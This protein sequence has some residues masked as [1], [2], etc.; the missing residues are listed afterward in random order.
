MPNR[1]R[2]VPA[3]IVDAVP[4]PTAEN[5]RSIGV[6]LLE[7]T[8]FGPLVSLHSRLF[9]VNEC[10]RH[11]RPRKAGAKLVFGIT[12]LPRSIVYCLN[13]KGLIKNWSDI[14]SGAIPD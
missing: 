4:G 10:A 7:Q 12:L 5:F 1:G 6:D 3:N 14:A 2:S 11:L 13:W 8:M 9:G